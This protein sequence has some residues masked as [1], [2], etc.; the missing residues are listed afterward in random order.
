MYKRQLLNEIIIKGN[1]AAIK[2]NGDTTEY[3]ASAYKVEPNA[4]EEDLLKRF[5]GL[6][7]DK[8]GNITANGKRVNKVLV[9]GEEFFGDDPTLV[10]RNI[11]A[12]MVDKVQLLSLI[13][14]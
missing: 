6:Q 2:S 4:K 7:I 14:I 5:P 8:N 10:T 1:A 13:H 12:D 9:D 3:N 11:R